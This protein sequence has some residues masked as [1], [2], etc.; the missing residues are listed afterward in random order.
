MQEE[1]INFV[2]YQFPSNLTLPAPT[3]NDVYVI[4]AFFF[5]GP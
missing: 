3:N 2:G 5:F 4:T 1:L